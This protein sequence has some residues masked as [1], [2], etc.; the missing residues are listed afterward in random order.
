MEKWLKLYAT[1]TVSTSPN[2][3]HRTT[4]L[5]TDVPNCYISLEF[6]ICKTISDDWI[7]I[8]VYWY[9]IVLRKQLVPW[10]IGSTLSKF[11]LEMCLACTDTSMHTTAPLAD[12]ASTIDWSSCAHSSSRR[13]LS[14]SRLSWSGKPSPV[15][16]FRSSD[17]VVY[18]VKVRRIRWPQCWRN[19]VRRLSLQCYVTILTFEHL[20]LTR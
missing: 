18:R 4:L 16:H 2:L 10:H 9:M 14:S 19:E 5:N 17:A 15:V 12:N 11:L 6:I 13:V 7:D 8:S 20:C 3:C 1:Y